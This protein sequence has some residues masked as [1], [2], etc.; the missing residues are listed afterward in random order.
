MSYGW[1]PLPVRSDSLICFFYTP[2]THVYRKMFSVNTFFFSHIFYVDSTVVPF[3]VVDF[4]VIR[5]P[6]NGDQ[7][8]SNKGRITMHHHQ[9]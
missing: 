4:H 9:A 2:V 3:E 6:L 8:S 1:L 5:V 7:F